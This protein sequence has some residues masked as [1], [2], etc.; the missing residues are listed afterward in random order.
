MEVSELMDRYGLHSRQSLYARLKSLGLV[1]NKGDRNKVYAT[2]EQVQLLDELNEHLKNGGTLK[3]FLPPT[4]TLP[5]Q[6]S[7]AEVLPS[8]EIS[9]SNEHQMLEMLVG[10]IAT[11]I[12]PRSPLWYHEELEKALINEWILTSKEVQSLVGVNPRVTKGNTFIRG[13][14]KFV[15]NGM[16]G[17][18]VAWK[19]ERFHN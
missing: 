18:S 16:I 3:S 8:N 12:Q 11:N 17:R 19:V 15:R 14:W 7:V 4:K 2:D 13:N 1:L 5:M 9:I 6:E 10:A